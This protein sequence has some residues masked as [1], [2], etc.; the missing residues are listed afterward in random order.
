MVAMITAFVLAS[1]ACVICSVAMAATGRNVQAIYLVA[2]AI[3]FL[4]LAQ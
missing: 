4:T 1:A 3:Y 2:V